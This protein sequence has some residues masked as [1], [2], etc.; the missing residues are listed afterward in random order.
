MNIAKL[1]EAEKKFLEKYPSGFNHPE[2]VEIVKKHKLDLRVKFCHENFALDKFDNPAVIVDNMIKIVSRSSLVSLFEKPKFRD[3]VNMFDPGQKMEL[4]IA[5]KELLHGNEKI[6]FNLLVD[7]LKDYKLAKWTLI[8]VIP[9]YYN[10]QYDV[11]IKPTTVKGILKLMEIEDIKYK[12][13]PTYEF[14]TRYRDYINEMK[15]HVDA[16]LSDSNA[17]FSGFLMMSM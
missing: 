9:T 14:Y 5:L 6:G 12:P 10:P 17:G 8:T 2:M 13:T 1:K 3:A 11:F 4:S 15:T 7:I 16:S